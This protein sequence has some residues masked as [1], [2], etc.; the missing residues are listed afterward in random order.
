MPYWVWIDNALLLAP[1][2]TFIW[3]L[4]LCSYTWPEAW[5]ESYISPLPKVAIPSQHQDF[6]GIIVTPVITRCFEKVVYQFEEILGPTQYA[7]REGC[8]CT[9]GLINMQYNCLKVLDDRKC[10]YVRL[11]A[12]DMDFLRHLK[13]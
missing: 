10:R 9:D 11:F 4:T 5:K 3:N 6:R 2:V 13:T 8:N 7:H 12:M 1:V